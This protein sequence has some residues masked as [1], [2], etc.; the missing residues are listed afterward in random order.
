MFCRVCQYA[1]PALNRQKQIGIKYACPRTHKVCQLLD[2]I[3]VCYE[4]WSM[5]RAS[6]RIHLLFYRLQ[7][8]EVVSCHKTSTLPD[9]TVETL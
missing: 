7:E 3:G 1:P 6:V 5:E 2:S 8:E 4:C 9:V